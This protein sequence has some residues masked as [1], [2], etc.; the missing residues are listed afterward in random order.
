[1]PTAL[2]AVSMGMMVGFL[3]GCS[4]HA[5]TLI[6]CGMG[7]EVEFQGA[8]SSP[9]IYQIEVVSDGAPA[10][11]QLTIPFTC[12][13]PPT[14]SP[15]VPDWRLIWSG[16]ALGPEHQTIDG[17]A[18]SS[19]GPTSIDVIVRHDDQVIGG[20]SAT[21]TYSTSRPNG[22]DCEPVCRSAPR[23]PIVL[24]PTRALR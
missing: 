6:G 24:A 9:G 7:L 3:D 20:G 18:F 4:S 22:P 2:I 13:T 14:C 15:A 23:F 1:M 5:C 12:G 11:C 10:T 16:C 19:G 21:P 8:K 17:L